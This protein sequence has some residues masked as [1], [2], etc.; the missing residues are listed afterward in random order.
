M[1]G[2]Y[3][4]SGFRQAEVNG[5]LITNYQNDPSLLAIEVTIK[6]GP[7]TRVAWVRIEGTYTLPQEDLPEIQTAE[8]QGFDESTLAD[9]RDPILGKYFNGGFPNA[10][11]DVAYVTAPPEPDGLPRVGVTFTI[12]EGEQFFIESGFSGRPGTY[13][14]R[15]CAART[16]RA[17]AANR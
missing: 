4:A 9:D 1:Q 6:E 11:V 7:Q 10:T 8:G 16:A 3:R 5:K 2:L 12:H 17:S 15:G 14:S 13:A